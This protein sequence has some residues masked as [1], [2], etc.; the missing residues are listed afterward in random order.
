MCRDDPERVSQRT[1]CPILLRSSA[2][3][4][5]QTNTLRLFR[6][7][8]SSRTLKTTRQIHSWAE[9]ALLFLTRSSCWSVGMRYSCWS[10]AALWIQERSSDAFPSNPSDAHRNSIS[11]HLL[12]LKT[13]EYDRMSVWVS[14]V[15]SGGCCITWAR[16]PQ[17]QVSARGSARSRWFGRR[18]TVLHIPK[19]FNKRVCQLEEHKSLSHKLACVLPRQHF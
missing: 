13:Q 1:T 8:Y 16:A 10:S 11:I 18:D 3:K 15:G 17:P 9:D 2:F 6:H 4:R 19:R 5:V 12:L 14:S 7:R